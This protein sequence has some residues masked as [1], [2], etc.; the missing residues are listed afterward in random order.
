MIGQLS[1]EKIGLIRVPKHLTDMLSLRD[2]FCSIMKT[3]YNL[4]EALWN[5]LP[6]Q[7]SYFVACLKEIIF[8][9]KECVLIDRSD[10]IVKWM[11]CLSYYFAFQDLLNL[12]SF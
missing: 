9:T 2:S 7:L 1:W 6:V 10:V 11:S 8:L 5:N 3:R 4:E 12:Y